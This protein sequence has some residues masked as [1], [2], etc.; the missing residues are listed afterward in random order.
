MVAFVSAASFSFEERFRFKAGCRCA[1]YVEGKN[2]AKVPDDIETEA[3]GLFCGRW[4]CRCRPLTPATHR[5]DS[6]HLALSQGARRARC[7]SGSRR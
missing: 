4:R 1:T 2:V 3:A 5:R 7:T 6:D